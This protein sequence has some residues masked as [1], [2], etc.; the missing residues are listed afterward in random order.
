[1]AFEVID[2]TPGLSLQSVAHIL[3][4]GRGRTGFGSSLTREG[5]ARVET[6]AALYWEVL[7]PRNGRI[8]CAGYKSPVDDK[9][10]PWSPPDSPSECF[11]GTPEADLMSAGLRSRGIPSDI[12]SVERHSIDSVT[13]LICAELE[14][15]FGDER[16]VA[17]VAQYG[18]LRR[19]L[20]II[21][22]RTLR[23]PYL[24][25]VVREAG[26]DHQGESPLAA[27]ASRFILA[28][29]PADCDNAIDVA[30]ARAARV[31]RLAR[32]VGFCRYPR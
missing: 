17:I 19:I 22:P 25:V 26:P 5:I 31:W 29:L 27:L 16:P 24:G 11:I 2:G 20:Q 18:H 4:P 15:H 12:V 1:M 14:G 3:I 10:R 32:V 9:G 6:A 23:R 30:A 13:N 21:A 7:A 8:V 28:K